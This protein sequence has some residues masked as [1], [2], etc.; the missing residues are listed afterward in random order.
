NVASGVLAMIAADRIRFVATW[1]GDTTHVLEVVAAV[2]TY[3]FANA[4]LVAG[5][6][7]LSRGRTFAQ[8]WNEIYLDGVA[9]FLAFRGA[10]AAAALVLQ[11]Q[12]RNPAVISVAAVPAFLAYRSL[13]RDVERRREG[14]TN[15][16]AAQQAAETDPLTGLP[17]RRAFL[18][19]CQA[20]VERAQRIS[21]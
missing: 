16:K 8:V 14:L 7:S 1:G 10:R 3:H 13:K 5:A 9:Q 20:A 18:D 4:L 2:G 11:Q 17:N 19:H 6:L 21:Q 15:L 12:P